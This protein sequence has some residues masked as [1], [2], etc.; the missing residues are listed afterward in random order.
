MHLKSDMKF[1]VNDLFR[2]VELPYG[3]GNYSMVVMVPEGNNNVKHI[4]DALSPENWNNWLNAFYDSKDA[5]INLPKFK[6]EY[7]LKMN[8]VLKAMGMTEA[9]DESMADFSRINPDADLYISEVK[10]KSF[11]EV[12]EEGTEA[13]A[14]TSVGIG[15][16][17]MPDNY[18][19]ANKPFLF[20]IKEKNTNAI[21]FIGKIVE[22]VD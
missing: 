6:F 2:A 3:K 21:L 15:V 16:T 4:V 10:H 5:D 8:D 12:N 13:A 9:F 19:I 22:P 7:E 18:F 1:L 11:V 14:A 20:F 17:S